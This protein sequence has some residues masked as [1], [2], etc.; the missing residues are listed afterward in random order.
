LTPKK[1][2]ELY[3][4]L[5]QDVKYSV[6]IVDA[7]V[8]DTAVWSDN[9]N[10]NWLE[11]DCSVEILNELKPDKAILDCPSNNIPAFVHYIEE[12]VH[13]GI[14]IKAEFKAD[15]NYPAVAAA[16]IIAKV[17][18]DREIKKL[19][20]KYNVDFGSGYPSDPRTQ[21]FIQSN[22]NKFDFFRKS[23]ATY[24][25]AKKAGKQKKLGEY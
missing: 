20:D 23:W 2:E 1:R 14:E 11:A 5:V 16:S 8:I 15:L 17:T 7:S 10:L 12:R 9:T 19:K 13:K 3:Q 25:N 4:V 21:K 18:R 22:W 24:E 6:K